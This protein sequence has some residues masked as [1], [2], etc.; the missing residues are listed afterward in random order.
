MLKS[1]LLL[2]TILALGGTMPAYAQQAGEAAQPTSA[3]EPQEAIDEA[4]P[5]E[6]TSRRIW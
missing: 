2:G 5:A 1:T 4:P 6:I 3:T